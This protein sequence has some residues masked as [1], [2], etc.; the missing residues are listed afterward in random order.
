MRKL[1]E[2]GPVLPSLVNSTAGIDNEGCLPPE[3]VFF[4]NP[5]AFLTLPTALSYARD[6]TGGCESASQLKVGASKQTLPERDG[7]SVANC[8]QLAFQHPSLSTSPLLSTLLQLHQ[9]FQQA[10][11]AVRHEYVG[12]IVEFLGS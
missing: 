2:V 10:S 3:P 5:T 7:L 9:C 6:L 1:K 4:S 11:K 12:Y 8:L